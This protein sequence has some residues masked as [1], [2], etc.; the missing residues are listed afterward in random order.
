[1]T[2]LQKANM[3][4]ACEE[5]LAFSCHV[6][7]LRKTSSMR[8]CSLA[9]LILTHETLCL[10]R[11]LYFEHKTSETVHF[12]RRNMSFISLTPFDKDNVRVQSGIFFLETQPPISLTGRKLCA[13]ESAA[14]NNPHKSIYVL[15]NSVEDKIHLPLK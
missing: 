8:I 5:T 14:V 11:K 9:L 13:I 10:E 15:I 1:M 6:F 12:P 2:W 4:N 3:H 7:H